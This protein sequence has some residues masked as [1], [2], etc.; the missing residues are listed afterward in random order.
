VTSG[1]AR[2]QLQLEPTE[3]GNS[4]RGSTN[5]RMGAH[6]PL[7]AAR[8]GCPREERETGSLVGAHTYNVHVNRGKGQVA[9]ERESAVQESPGGF[10]QREAVLRHGDRDLQAKSRIG[11]TSN[12]GKT[13]T[14]VHRRPACRAEAAT[15][16]VA[17][18]CPDAS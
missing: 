1:Q 6:T 10:R 9:S 15:A 14:Q 5:R 12:H 2:P 3:S 4:E 11:T 16:V 8:A 13:Q 17:H 18:T 7:K